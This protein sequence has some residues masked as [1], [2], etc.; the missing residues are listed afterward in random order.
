M[1]FFFWG[2]VKSRVYTG[3]AY[4]D[5]ATLQQKITAECAQVPLQM[6]RDA[7][8]SYRDRLELCIDREGCSV[9]I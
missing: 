9:E 6:I 2:Y 4:P 5:I 7:I 8:R 3:L 1:D